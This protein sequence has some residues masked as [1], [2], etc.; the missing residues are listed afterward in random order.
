MGVG[1]SSNYNERDFEEKPLEDEEIEKLLEEL[2]SS[3]K[4]KSLTEIEKIKILKTTSDE[5]IYNVVGD[6]IFNYHIKNNKEDIKRCIGNQINDNKKSCPDDMISRIIT[7]EPGIIKEPLQERI[8]KNKQKLQSKFNEEKMSFIED[9]RK[10]GME[11]DKLSSDIKTRETKYKKEKQVFDEFWKGKETSWNEEKQNL[12]QVGNTY[13]SERDASRA[14]EKILQTTLSTK[15]KQWDETKKT[16]EEERSELTKGCDNA[17]QKI[18][19]EKDNLQKIKD[20]LQIDYKTLESAKKSLKDQYDTLT[21]NKTT[22]KGQYDN[23]LSTKNDLDTKIVNL[24]TEKNNFKIE[25]DEAR[26]TG[27]TYKTE[28]DTYKTERDTYKTERDT[29]KTERDNYK[30][31]SEKLDK[32][33]KELV[34]KIKMLSDP[35]GPYPVSKN[36]C[37]SS[38]TVSNIHSQVKYDDKFPNP[39]G[40]PAASSYWSEM[41]SGCAYYTDPASPDYNRLVFDTGADTFNNESN[42][43][44][45]GACDSGWCLPSASYRV[46]KNSDNTYKI[47]D[48]PKDKCSDNLFMVVGVNH[49]NGNDGKYFNYDLDAANDSLRNFNGGTVEN[50]K[51]YTVYNHRTN[52]IMNVV[53]WT[54]A[55]S[56]SN[57][58]VGIT[59]KGHGRRTDSLV[60]FVPGDNLSF[61]NNIKIHDSGSPIDNMSE[62]E[63]KAWA[64][65]SSDKA[66]RGSAEW[67]HFG[68]GCSAHKTD[69]GVWYNKKDTG[70]KCGTNSHTCVAKGKGIVAYPKIYTDNIEEK[71]SGHAAQNVSLGECKAYAVKNKLP[72]FGVEIDGGNF[73]PGC[74]FYKFKGY[75]SNHGVRYRVHKTR[76][77]K[78]CG[79]GQTTCI[80]KKIN[81]KVRTSGEPIP[82]VTD[83]ECHSW[84]DINNKGWVGKGNWDGDPKGCYTNGTNTWFNLKQTSH[85]C[86]KDNYSCVER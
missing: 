48:S 39:G 79:A 17:T 22:L 47:L 11:K 18:I 85:A 46:C 50:N 69:M 6:E 57:Y 31:E 60:Y 29:Y 40:K 23:L 1:Q 28:R 78:N 38:T 13:K 21:T 8:E 45:P 16:L 83:S 27:Q 9:K 84:A 55:N 26:T 67:D 10:W 30:N 15:E 82:N 49:S 76:D 36:E 77:P 63:C 71:D 33:V 61:V 3:D 2:P 32:Q 86:G 80:Q 34:L 53:L 25:R 70:V 56:K 75:E 14:K 7:Q 66:W 65:A 59:N 37:M 44:V 19:K 51:E 73:P 74:S 35:F 42:V 62:E 58:S 54:K 41:P 72:W 43:T 5:K 81:F 4:L 12:T 24:S 52:E 20:K 64:D 68:K